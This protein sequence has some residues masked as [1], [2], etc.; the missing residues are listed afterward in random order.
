ME[1]DRDSDILPGLRREERHGE[2]MRE[3]ERERREEEVEDD[4]EGSERKGD[5]VVERE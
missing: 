2:G 3:R 4:G 1:G 5:G